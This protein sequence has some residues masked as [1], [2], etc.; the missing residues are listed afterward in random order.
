MSEAIIVPASL[1]ALFQECVD[2]GIADAGSIENMTWKVKNDEVAAEH[3]TQLWGRRLQRYRP[4]GNTTRLSSR[5][6]VLTTDTLRMLVTPQYDKPNAIQN[7]VQQMVNQMVALDDD[8]VMHVLALASFESTCGLCTVCTRFNELIKTP[9]FHL[10]L[11]EMELV[12]MGRTRDR[13]RLA[14]DAACASLS[15]WEAMHPSAADAAEVEGARAANDGP[16]VAAQ[17]MQWGA[18]HARRGGCY[19]QWEQQRK[20]VLRI[21]PSTMELHNGFGGMSAWTWCA[22]KGPPEQL[23]FLHRH[24]ADVNGVSTSKDPGSGHVLNA[25]SNENDS[26]GLGP[27]SGAVKLQYAIDNGVDVIAAPDCQAWCALERLLRQR[28]GGEGALDMLDVFLLNGCRPKMEWLQWREAGTE[29]VPSVPRTT[30]LTARHDCVRLTTRSHQVPRRFAALVGS[31]STWKNRRRAIHLLAIF[32][33]GD[34]RKELLPAKSTARPPPPG[35]P[36]GRY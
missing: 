10:R 35:R 14:L 28:G 15:E 31:H 5:G 29:N 3:Y 32:C 20:D 34:W 21:R 19:E 27:S 8:L 2:I 18:A 6:Q 23:I 22:Y 12:R 13:C 1:V 30:G 9:T 26:D 17:P 11:R 7:F 4:R 24:G 16:G 36:P 33:D 25:T